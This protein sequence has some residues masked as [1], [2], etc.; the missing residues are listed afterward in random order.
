MSTNRSPRT[1]R[2]CKIPFWRFTAMNVLSL[3]QR[4]GEVHL[5]QTDRRTDRA[6]PWNHPLCSRCRHRLCSGAFSEN[7][8]SRG[9]IFVRVG[10]NAANPHGRSARES[11]SHPF[12]DEKLC[13]IPSPF[14]SV[15]VLTVR[16]GHA[17]CLSSQPGDGQLRDVRHCVTDSFSEASAWN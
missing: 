9:R 3:T 10:Q 2:Y 7:P 6:F 1:S 15:G 5:A 4:R 13:A 8:F 16:H 14:P 11:A 17:V 12:V